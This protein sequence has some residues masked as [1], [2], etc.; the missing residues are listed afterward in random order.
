MPSHSSISGFLPG[1]TPPAYIARACS[2]PQAPDLLQQIS[3]PSMRLAIAPTSTSISPTNP[4]VPGRPTEAS[5]I[6]I[7]KLAYRGITVPPRHRRQSL[8]YEAGH[9]PPRHRKIVQP[10]QAR[11][12]SSGTS[13]RQ[14][15][16]R[17][18]LKMPMV[19]IPIC[20]TDE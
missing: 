7:K 9:R 15:P 1:Q 13:P 20:A 18:R 8:W 5:I 6:N 19:T 2:T 14:S 17:F 12:R 3:L 10:R 11:E 16:V 4:D